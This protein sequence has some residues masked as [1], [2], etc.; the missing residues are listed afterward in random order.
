M[1]FPNSAMWKSKCS[2][3]QKGQSIVEFALVAL[4]FFIILFGIFDLGIM[5]YSYHFVSYAARDA[6]RWAIVHGADSASPATAED[7][8]NA[9]IPN[10]G[11]DPDKLTVSTEWPG[12]VTNEDCPEGS[13][14]RGCPVKVTVQYDFDF[15]LPFMPSNGI[16]MTSSSQMK[17]SY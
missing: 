16:T 13:N 10:P 8:E 9:V 6:T 15:L 5:A 11:I 2:A 12:D 17:I 14:M 7:V 1:R 3:D 4:A